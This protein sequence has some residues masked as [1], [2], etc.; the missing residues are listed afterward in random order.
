M[1]LASDDG[2]VLQ[3]ERRWQCRAQ[4]NLSAV[5]QS[6]LAHDD[7][8]HRFLM[9]RELR[10]SIALHRFAS[11]SARN[12]LHPSPGH[13]IPE[14]NGRRLY[15]VS[16]AQDRCVAFEFVMAQVDS[17]GANLTE[18]GFQP[19]AVDEIRNIFM[20]APGKPEHLAIGVGGIVK[21][22]ATQSIEENRLPVLQLALDHCDTV[23]RWRGLNE[24]ANSS[25][26][27]EVIRGC[28]EDSR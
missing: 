17:S 4:H 10:T 28:S 21:N 19:I 26:R 5:F 14:T 2:A 8:V 13:R 20:G 25:G 24:S 15:F 12:I 3:S 11:A 7:L 1:A 9:Q 23:R 22:D 16:T 18:R 27:L 6:E